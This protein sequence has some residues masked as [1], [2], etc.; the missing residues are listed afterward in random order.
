[1]VAEEARIAPHTRTRFVLPFPPLHQMTTPLLNFTDLGQMAYADAY[2]R[3]AA[4]VDEVLAWRESSGPVG[5]IFL[6]EHPA[7]VTVSR[8]PEARQHLIAS[9]QLLA[10]HGVEV[11]E[12]DR[13]GDITYHGPGQLVVYPI[14]DLNRLN[15]G[16]HEYMRLLE[17]AVINTCDEFGVA[18]MRDPKA[19]GV[20]T[21]H[22]GAPTSKICAMGVRVRRW[23]TMHGLAIN[24]TTNLD[25][26]NL[27]VPCGLVGRAVT[28]LQRECGPHTPSMDDVK[29]VLCVN[30][31]SLIAD[32]KHKAEIAR[33]SAAQ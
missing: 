1:M 16:L 26:F 2:A 13:G 28:S 31:E 8:R 12:T 11:A 7:V 30:L 14:V 29:R 19:T 33:K 24:V 4:T 32:A 3:Q 10:S 22:N 25:H 27:I 21:T 5:R 15:L 6:V 23:V 20:W 18:T 17:E 9:P